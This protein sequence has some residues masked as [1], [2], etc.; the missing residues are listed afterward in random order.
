MRKIEPT[1]DKNIQHEEKYNLEHVK[2]YNMG[3]IKST[4][5][6]NIQRSEL[7]RQCKGAEHSSQILFYNF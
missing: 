4:A 5:F 7:I 6:E 3:K 2:T 1:A